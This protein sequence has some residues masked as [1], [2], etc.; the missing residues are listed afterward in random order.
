MVLV[1]HLLIKTLAAASLTGPIALLI[2]PSLARW[3]TLFVAQ[4]PPARP[5]GLGAEFAAGL[6]RA[7]WIGAAIIP[8]L[9]IALGLPRSIIAAIAAVLVTAG[10]IHLARSRLGGVTGDVLGMTIEV[11]EAVVLL[12][13]CLTRV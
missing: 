10:I 9:L 8:I 13:F 2:A 6:T 5:G 7:I 11:V 4:Q 12:A 1:M 3:L